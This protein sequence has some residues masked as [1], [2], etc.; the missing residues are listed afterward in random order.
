MNNPLVSV[1][2]S[3]KNTE[4]TLKKCILSI[5]DQSYGNIEIIVVD[6][7]SSDATLQI[8]EQH[9][10]LA[11]TKGPE[12]STQRNFGF[13]KAQGKYFCCIDADMILTPDVI[14][15]CVEKLESSNLDALVIHEESIGEGFWAQ[16]KALE[17][18]SYSNDENIEAGRFYKREVYETVGGFNAKLI[19]AEDWD[20]HQRMEDAGYKFGSVKPIILHDEGKIR[21]WDLCKKKR[22]YGSKLPDFVSEQ[23]KHNGFLFLFKRLY[24]FRKSLWSNWRTYIQHPI[25]TI[26]MII[27]LFCEK[28]FGGIGFIEGML[29]K[30]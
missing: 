17:R 3:T 25:R 23:K 28:L 29:K 15:A 8:A 24:I 9:A 13:S 11:L 4:R 6:N 30:S 1:V 20:L 7:K 26:G 27:M 22:Y 18:S 14:F 12:R 2:I 10:D 5:R 16:C 19:A 21:L